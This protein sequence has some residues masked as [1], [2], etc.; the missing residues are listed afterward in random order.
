MT[1]GCSSAQIR[2]RCASAKLPKP[3][4][5]LSNVQLVGT[6]E[7]LAQNQAAL[8]QTQNQLTGLAQ[9]RMQLVAAADAQKRQ[10]A[11]EVTQLEDI[12]EQTELEVEALIREK[13]A[14]EAAR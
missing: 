14:E 6:R 12:S 7:Q 13:Q 11:Q 8:A 9:E 4:S 5:P 1:F 3:K 2:K 10:V